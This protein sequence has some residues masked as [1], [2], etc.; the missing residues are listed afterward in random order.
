MRR[1]AFLVPVLL[2]AS[3]GSAQAASFTFET[4]PLGTYTSL[5]VSDSGQ[6][7]TLTRTSGNVFAVAN[8]N[9]HPA[10][11]GSVTVQN[12]V[13]QTFPAGDAYNA[14]FSVPLNHFSIQFGDF[15]PSD[16]DSP[17]VLMA[18]S[19]LNGTGTFLGSTSVPW[20]GSDSFPNFGVLS[21]SSA[22]QI[23]SVRFFGS[24]SQFHNS[25]FWDNITT[26]DDFGEVP[27]PA[28]LVLLGSG[29][30]GAA[31]ARRRSKKK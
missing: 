11:W 19:G 13:D 30:L 24:G 20:L 18:F 16:D 25:L 17:V 2:A 14:N 23:R 3:V 27:E 15:G 9:G 5:V 29:L 8:T 21:F 26:R 1:F 22:S 31:A 7:M 10:G 4:T 28:T 12:F 6:T